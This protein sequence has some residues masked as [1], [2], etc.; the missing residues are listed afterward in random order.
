MP[1]ASG[2]SLLLK[3]FSG[4][5]HLFWNKCEMLPFIKGKVM[6]LPVSDSANF[7]HL[8]ITSM[9]SI[10]SQAP[11]AV[12]PFWSSPTHLP[13]KQLFLTTT[14]RS[15][16]CLFLPSPLLSRLTGICLEYCPLHASSSQ[17]NTAKTSCFLQLQGFVQATSVT[18]LL[19]LKSLHP[20]QKVW[21]RMCCF[22]TSTISPLAPLNSSLG[23]ESL[24]YSLSAIS[25]R[26]WVGLAKITA[27]III[28]MGSLNY[29]QVS[30]TG[31]WPR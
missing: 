21:N 12:L 18:A 26:I 25:P 17:F 3:H 28:I 15:K 20:P 27:T 5:S 7:P 6:L 10:W 14:T 31:G 30:V 22:L 23:W 13:V 1:T 8:S 24:S 16:S 2:K 9:C 29:K 4:I 11:Q 19:F